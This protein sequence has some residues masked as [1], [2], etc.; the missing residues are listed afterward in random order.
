MVLHNP[1]SLEVQEE[2]VLEGYRNRIN[3]VG[4]GVTAS[5]DAVNDRTDIIIGIGTTGIFGELLGGNTAIVI[6]NDAPADV[7]T[8]AALLRTDGYNVWVCDGTADDVQIQAAIDALTS[9]GR[10]I[11]SQ[12]TFYI[13]TSI[14]F[15]NT[16]GIILEGMGQE[17]TIL[18]L[19]NSA[20]TDIIDE[21]NFLGYISIRNMTLDGNKDNNAAGKCIELST[22]YSVF[23]NLTVEYAAE[24][25]MDFELGT[26][27]GN[28]GIGNVFHNIRIEYCDGHGFQMGVNG[29]AGGA[30]DCRFTN[31][32]VRENGG[33]G[34]HFENGGA[35]QMSNMMVYR[36]DGDGLFFG[37]GSGNLKL[38]NLACDSNGYHGVHFE[39]NGGS[40]STITDAMIRGNSVDS[41]GTYSGVYVDGEST[42]YCTLGLNNIIIASLE[43]V[44]HKYA[45]SI[46]DVIA[47]SGASVVING[48]IYFTGTDGVL[49]DNTGNVHWIMNTIPATERHGTDAVYIGEIDHADLTDGGGLVAYWEFP[50]TIIPGTEFVSVYCDIEEAFKDT[51]G[52]NTLVYFQVGTSADPDRFYVQA[53]PGNNIWNSTTD[54]YNGAID[55]QGAARNTGNTTIRCTFTTDSDATDLISGAGSQGKMT[56]YFRFRY[57]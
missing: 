50:Q 22:Y 34:L 41:N 6:S 7:K 24:E 19:A 39:G 4:S 31:F 44:D 51:V 1:F 23:E 37:D 20:N 30:S 9:G 2:G 47:S 40:Y 16:S 49:H 13:S 54:R 48:G 29:G 32:D 18:K 56:V 10:V 28:N 46:E 43:G 57:Y 35:H 53:S 52:S 42:G 3:M 33:D 45:V 17:A 14:D 27:V 36:N 55:A 5:W 11:L 12:G 26:I 38:V 15:N 25:G 8:Y 21:P